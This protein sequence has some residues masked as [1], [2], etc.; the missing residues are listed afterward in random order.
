MIIKLIEICITIYTHNEIYH[1]IFLIWQIS[2]IVHFH[3]T[4]IFLNFKNYI[5]KNNFETV[6]GISLSTYFMTRIVCL[7]H[8]FFF[9][10]AGGW[11]LQPLRITTSP[12]LLSSAS[13]LFVCCGRGQVSLTISVSQAGLDLWYSCNS[14]LQC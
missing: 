9:L 13:F 5:T 4:V 11:S 7:F 2:H 14:V 1:M 8:F 3:I 12:T 10:S 6:L